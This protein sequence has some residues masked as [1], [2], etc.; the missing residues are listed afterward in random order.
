MGKK[1]KQYSTKY[2][3]ARE[4][5][6]HVGEILYSYISIYFTEHLLFTKTPRGIQENIK[7]TPFLQGTAD[8]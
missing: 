7:D 1:E 5:L 3:N 4:D 2:E 6:E 8:Q